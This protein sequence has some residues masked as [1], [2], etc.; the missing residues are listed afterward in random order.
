MKEYRDIFQTVWGVALLLMG[1][2]VF[3]RIPYLMEQVA[4]IEYFVSILVFIRVCFYLIGI[5]LIGGGIKKL[6]GLWYPRGQA[7]NAGSQ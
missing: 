6:Y 5:I 4:D 3:F 1:I 7:N 2:G